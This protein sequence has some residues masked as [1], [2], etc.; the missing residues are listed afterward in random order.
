[1]KKGN[2]KRLC[3]YCRVPYPRSDEGLMMQMTNRIGKNDPEAIHELG[4]AY[5]RGRAGLPRDYTKA[6]ELWKRAAELGC[7]RA[8]NALSGAYQHSQG[9]EKDMEKAMHHCT[10]AAIGGHEYARHTLGLFEAL[11]GNMSIAMKHFII[12]AMSGLEEALKEVGE[13]YR[14]GHVTKDEYANTLRSHQDSCEEMK[15][16]SRARAIEY[17]ES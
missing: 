5:Y 17:S 3:P 2:M 8:H 14:A 9:V 4:S 10:L 1:M 15:S 13:G 12:A 6:T 11:D 7:A 16:E